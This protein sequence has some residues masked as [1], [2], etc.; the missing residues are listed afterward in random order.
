MS[1]PPAGPQLDENL[2]A[3]ALQQLRANVYPLLPPPRFKT[4]L[5][6]LFSLAAIGFVGYSILLFIVLLD[7]RRRRGGLW[8]LRRTR[9]NR[10]IVSNTKLC[11]CLL[12]VCALFITSLAVASL[13]SNIVR[14]NHSFFAQ[15]C[16]AVFQVIYIVPFV[17][18]GSL[19]SFG[20]LQAFL[21]RADSFAQTDN[22][23]GTKR[24]RP[25]LSARLANGLFLG[26]QVLVLGVVVVSLYLAIHGAMV[27]RTLISPLDHRLQRGSEI[28]MT[29]DHDQ[30]DFD[31]VVPMIQEAVET[32]AKYGKTFFAL[33]AL[34]A[35]NLAAL[36]L[37]NVGSIL[38]A[39]LVRG[40]AHRQLAS[41][42]TS[43]TLV[44][45]PTTASPVDLMPSTSQSR[46]AQ[47]PSIISLESKSD[48]ERDRDLEK[49]PMSHRQVKELAGK[50]SYTLEGQMAQRVLALLKAERA[51]RVTA[52]WLLA[53]SI[54]ATTISCWLAFAVVGIK[55]NGGGWKN[56]G[57]WAQELTLT[58]FIWLYTVLLVSILPS[59]LYTA[60]TTL[61]PRS[62]GLNASSS[63]HNTLHEAPSLRNLL[64]RRKQ[65]APTP[66]GL[67][68]TGR[69]RVII[70]YVVEDDYVQD[71][72]TPD[73]AIVLHETRTMIRGGRD[74]SAMPTI[75]I[76]HVNEDGSPLEVGGN[77]VARDNNW[78]KPDWARG[79]RGEEGM[80]GLQ[81][82]LEGG[83]VRRESTNVLPRISSLTGGIRW[84]WKLGPSSSS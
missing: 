26:G 2:W 73:D 65:T 76:V 48:A 56:D 16:A 53:T 14:R 52:S 10:Y 62:N 27:Y 54:V 60:F 66:A 8:V 3:L 35:A 82:T 11:S 5:I 78:G 81:P 79:D 36:T 9:G 57:W 47:Q 29:G 59:L 45:V 68:P 7:G 33:F 40:K 22:G 13:Y 30:K 42:A 49:L 18:H 84:E 21:I 39:R 77:G 6:A 41:S 15:Q 23:A 44:E 24:S 72:R 70:D 64:S 61:T 37:V 58:I 55:N 51:L 67:A 17:M 1:S 83:R 71:Y 12:A 43:A 38:F 19:L 25:L 28:W 4:R 32:G 80:Q 63:H 20:A 46:L 31:V 50:G 34:V 74:S 69:V 75:S